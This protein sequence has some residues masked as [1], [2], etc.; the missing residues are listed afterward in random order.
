MSKDSFTDSTTY[1]IASYSPGYKINLLPVSI[2]A[3][4][5]SYHEI[6]IAEEMLVEQFFTF[7]S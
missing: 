3:F 1:R 4:R 6:C 2:F 7:W 5:Q